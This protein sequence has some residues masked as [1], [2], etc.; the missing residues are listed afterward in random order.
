[1]G[2]DTSWGGTVR[3]DNYTMA[4]GSGECGSCKDANRICE[5]S[6]CQDNEIP[7]R[8][9]VSLP[10]MASNGNCPV[11]PAM[12]Q[13]VVAN[14][15]GKTEDGCL[16]TAAPFENCSNSGGRA[17]VATLTLTLKHN[18]TTDKIEATVVMVQ[19]L[20]PKYYHDPSYLGGFLSFWYKWKTEIDRPADCEELTAGLP[21][22]SV[23]ST[24]S[25]PTVIAPMCDATGTSVDI[26]AL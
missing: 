6:G 4:S 25:G 22:H 7:E 24:D 13:T 19:A 10:A 5:D 18:A 3:F 21:L 23:S 2:A 26:E 14:Y 11:C 15:A 9:K 17:D 16:W 8:F 1:V 20:L 12:A